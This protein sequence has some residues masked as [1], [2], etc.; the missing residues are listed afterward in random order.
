[1]LSRAK[2]KGWKE[3]LLSMGGKEILIKS[4]AQAVPVYAMMAFKIL[5]NICKGISD[6]ISQFWWGDEY[7]HKKI[8][9]KAWWKLCIPKKRGGMGFR[10]LES[11]NLAL[12]AKQIW[13]LLLELDSLCAR[14][15]RARYYPDGKLLNAKLKSGSSYTWQSILTGLECFKHGYIWRVGDG[16]Q[17][18]IWEDCWIPSSHNLKI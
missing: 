7:D 12:L 16:S 4:I 9:W 18:N 17:I 13:R 14:V 15:L 10:D 11:F 8:H 5:K 2:T 1:M 3:K 6:T